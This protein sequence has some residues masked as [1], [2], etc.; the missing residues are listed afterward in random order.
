MS[1]GLKQ[2]ALQVQDSGLIKVNWA[3]GDDTDRDKAAWDIRL[4]QDDGAAKDAAG[5]EVTPDEG[6]RCCA[7]CLSDRCGPRAG[8]E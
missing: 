2:V 7:V 1:T 5:E 8:S 4:P 6:K 3:D